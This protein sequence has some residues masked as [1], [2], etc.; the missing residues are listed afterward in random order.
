MYSVIEEPDVEVM[1]EAVAKIRSVDP[2]RVSVNKVAYSAGSK[3]GENFASAMKKAV[4]NGVLTSDDGGVEFE[5]ILMCKFPPK[6]ENAGDWFEHM[7]LFQRESEFYKDYLPNVAELLLRH[8]YYVPF[9]RCGHA[10][11]LES[12]IIME[13]AKLA[14]FAVDEAAKCLSLRRL[15]AIMDALAP[16][17]AAGHKLWV[18]LGQES[19]FK[20]F[21]LIAT[22]ADDGLY[23]TKHPKT[24]EYMNEIFGSIIQKSIST[25]RDLLGNSCTGQLTAL[26]MLRISD[27]S[28]H[29]RMKECVSSNRIY[30]LCA[31]KRRRR[32]QDDFLTAA[33]GDLWNNNIMF[34]G[35]SGRVRFVDAQNVCLTRPAIDLAL[36]FYQSTTP[37][38]RELHSEALLKRYHDQLSRAL[39][40]MGFEENRYKFETLKEDF[41]DFFVQGFAMG[42]VNI[43]VS[44]FSK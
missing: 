15:E 42:F 10:G 30:D 34:H 5:Q 33:H 28:F 18:D 32:R 12:G 20:K 44:T 23:S 43:I 25:I 31:E 7:G 19:Y 2:S 29:D 39:K 3:L 40:A 4:V 26:N 27:P 21:P 36:L 11:G 41:E 13:D 17:H 35:E 22:C 1:R 6:D 14:G 9:V 37:E 8:G 24:V 38:T 16:F